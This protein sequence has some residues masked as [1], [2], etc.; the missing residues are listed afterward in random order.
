MRDPTYGRIDPD[1]QEMVDEMNPPTLGS[2][3][4]MENTLQ[5]RRDAGR[6][7]DGPLRPPYAIDD[8][9]DPGRRVP[10]SW[11]LEAAIERRRADLVD[12]IVRL[13]ERS[14]GPMPQELRTL[15][16]ATL[17]GVVGVGV[18]LLAG[19]VIPVRIGPTLSLVLGAGG[20][21]IG[22]AIGYVWGSR[23]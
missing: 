20:A 18:M 10:A 4:A 19:W 22:W 8:V 2:R 23:P 12:Q 3:V 1:I 13:S 21:L 5:A 16:T 6:H 14:R 9:D 15:L 7:E 11:W 17:G